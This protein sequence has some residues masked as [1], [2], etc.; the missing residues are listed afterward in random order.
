M[1][2]AHFQFP[3]QPL[4]W[5]WIIIDSLLLLVKQ[6]ALQQHQIMTMWLQHRYCNWGFI[7]MDVPERCHRL[8][9][10][11]SDCWHP[12]PCQI[13]SPYLEDLN[14]KKAWLFHK[15]GR[16][17]NARLGT[18]I[19]TYSIPFSASLG[20]VKWPR[21]LLC[22]G[23]KKDPTALISQ[24]FSMSIPDPFWGKISMTSLK[25]S[26]PIFLCTFITQ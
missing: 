23:K 1:D 20:S 18:Q 15:R 11:S 8:V 10:V 19:F 4:K 3:K 13:Q 9:T 25:F 17:E 21:H 16:W 5:E 26:Y 24:G 6:E 2:I 12:D 22:I 14:G 7:H